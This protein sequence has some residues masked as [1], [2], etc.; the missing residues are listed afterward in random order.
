LLHYFFK[1]NYIKQKKNY[2]RNKRSRNENYSSTSKKENNSFQDYIATGEKCHYKRQTL[3]IDKVSNAVGETVVISDVYKGDLKDNV[4]Y[5][6]EKSFFK[7]K[8]YGVFKY[9]LR[10]FN[11][12]SIVKYMVKK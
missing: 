9:K 10:I 3:N 4:L 1:L 8:Y 11:D 7:N 6:V 2:K 12:S 5:K